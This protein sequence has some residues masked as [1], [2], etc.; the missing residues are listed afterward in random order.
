MIEPDFSTNFNPSDAAADNGATLGADVP[1]ELKPAIDGALDFLRDLYP[2]GPWAL[3]S[4]HSEPGPTETRTFTPSRADRAARWIEAQQ[5]RGRNVYYALNTPT[6]EVANKKAKKHEIDEIIGVQV[7]IDFEGPGTA[8][9]RVQIPKRLSEY[10][11]QPTYI[12]FS[13]GGYQAVWLLEERLKG[14][15][16]DPITGELATVIDFKTKKQ[17]HVQSH[18]SKR[19]ELLN[20]Q[21]MQELGGDP[22]AW[23]I[24]RILRLPGT[25]NF[26]NAR[27]I[28]KGRVP[29]LARVVETHWERRINPEL[30]DLD[31]AASQGASPG[32]RRRAKPNGKA[33]EATNEGPE[34]PDRTAGAGDWAERLERL[35]GWLQDA[36]TSGHTER[37]KKAKKGGD[38]SIA[39]FAVACGLVRAGWADDDIVALLL[40]P[41]FPI[42]EHCRAQSNPRQYA[43]RQ[44]AK[45]REKI[46]E[47]DDELSKLIE[48][49]NRQYA[50]VNEAGKA[51]IYERVKDPV[52]D[53]FVIV[54]FAFIDFQRFYM[55]KRLSIEFPG[56]GRPKVITKTLADWWLDHEQR[57]EYLGG[58]VFD[59]TGKAPANCWNLWSGFSVEPKPGDWSL[60]R[61]HI[62]HVICSGNQTHADYLL[63]LFARMFQYPNEP[64]EVAVVL[65]G[66]KR[67]GKGILCNWVVHAWGQHGLRIGHA[68]HLTGNFN[69]HLRDCVCLFADEAFF[70]ANP[71][72]EGVLKGLITDPTIAVEGKYKS[73][74]SVLNMLHILMASNSDW[75]VPASHDEGRY[76]VLGVSS[77][78]IGDRQ[79]F[80]ALNEQMQN[81]GLAAMIHDLLH[82]DI[83]GFE[84]RD[85][86]QTEALAEQKMLSLDT[87]D[88][89]WLAVLERGFVWESRYGETEF[90]DWWP[91][92]ST[93][94][95]HKSYLQWCARNRV[96]W[97]MDVTLLG[98]RMT[99]MY[100]AARPRGEAVIGEV[101]AAGNEEPKVIYQDRPHGYNVGELDEARARFAEVRKVVGVWQNAVEPAQEEREEEVP[102]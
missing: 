11:W 59:P 58:V 94:L 24:D 20:Q 41:A 37:S 91:F 36:I 13:G 101:E 56:P 30:P 68:A 46:E 55:N 97:P 29:A 33:E 95:L 54:R 71:Q 79:Y 72:H 22:S 4:I 27:K 21:L 47:S 23:N 53:R 81:G 12:N 40:D 7:D 15:A 77:H 28:E 60:M 100:R 25:I 45:A 52:L 18:D 90:L 82:R 65:R 67:C 5:R 99:D 38:R 26:P 86:P 62:D 93:Q 17:I 89:W 19:I 9:E 98:K 2:R 92:V 34:E 70:A 63:N 57:R 48:R 8:E 69:D 1:S 49:F 76:F 73:V 75:V 96:A 42:S 85:I 10:R 61:A 87:L 66:L 16:I 43:Q 83:S 88:K 74:V 64:G 31:E 78:K 3:T 84:V 6:P 35:P 50:V 51:V 102:F 80:K 39:V 14:R 32:N 44:A